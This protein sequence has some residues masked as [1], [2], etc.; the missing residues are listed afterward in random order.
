MLTLLPPPKRI[1]LL[2]GNFQ[3]AGKYIYLDA[4]CPLA[5]Q[6]AGNA[7]KAALQTN[8]RPFELTA[9]RGTDAI[10]VTVDI[11]PDAIVYAEGYSLTIAPSKISIVAHDPAGALYAAMTLK[12]IV[13][14]CTPP[15]AALPCLCIND[16]PDF[17][18]RG[19][20]LDI[21]RDKVPSMKTLFGLIDLLSEWK[22]N[23][24]Q[25]YTEHTFAYRQHQSVWADAS[26]M[27][28]EQIMELD[29]YCIERNVELVPNQNSFGHME[30]WL[31]VP[32][33]THL[34]ESA[35]G[36]IDPWGNK[37]GAYGLCPIEPKSI[38][39]LEDLYNELLPHFSSRKFN[40][41]CD[42][43][44][45]LGKGLSKQACEARGTGRVYLEFLLKI[46]NVAR[47]NNR[48]MQFW[49]DIILHHPELISELPRDAVA[50]EW[51][52]EAD[53]PFQ[54]HCARFAE[55]RIPYYVCPGTSA[56]NSISGRTDN[57]IAN[58]TRAAETGLSSG[59]A[60]L[61]NTDWGDNG[62]W[63]H[64]PVSYLGYAS[65][66]AASWN[67][68]GS[69][70]LDLPMALSLHAFHDP[71]LRMGKLAFDLGNMYQK[72]GV[73]IPNNSILALILLRAETPV[74]HARAMG[75]T[76]G[77]LEE[78][79]EWIDRVTGPLSSIHG[80]SITKDEFA[81]TAS[82]LRF[83]CRLGIGRLQYDRM[84]AFPEGLRHD[85]TVDLDS[86][87]SQYETIWRIRNKPGGLKE[88]IGRM[89]CIL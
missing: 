79:L 26:P 85:L 8:E 5:L 73:S 68:M 13:R 22:I 36:C 62:H 18:V 30:R 88:S 74:A 87:M 66:A 57:A 6:H 83:A 43:T 7:I 60:G 37:R 47:R 55:S 34:A 80:D 39:F 48:V 4:A 14:Q 81:N 38:Q 78:T 64:L 51:G 65:G 11:S 50:L 54:E 89:K 19:V 29:R 33:Y 23:Q 20:M 42:E 15:R 3:P 46:Y 52:Y 31:S 69:K 67:L 35:E 32:A 45:D 86:I 82:L 63:Q 75:L 41:G 27:T 84:E 71:S 72:T 44:F 10:A 59:C 25:L 58:I 77:K 1:E 40:V 2:G 49:G 28:G 12:Q 76:A 70:S 16:W 53:H 61:L 21:S 17:N 56:W 24:F 9:F